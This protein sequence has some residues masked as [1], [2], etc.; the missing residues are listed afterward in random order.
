MSVLSRSPTMA[1]SAG[2]TP[3]PS[4]AIWAIGASGLP[5]VRSQRTPVVASIAATMPAVSGSPRPAGNGQY[6]SGLVLINRARSEERRVGKEDRH[7]RAE[8]PP[9]KKRL[10]RREAD[11][12]GEQDCSGKTN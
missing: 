12:A 6:R 4:R 9:K 8:R 5:K 2:S 10:H 7:P 1:H 3:T 11:E